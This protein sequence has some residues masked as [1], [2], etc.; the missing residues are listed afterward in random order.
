MDHVD[1][2]VFPITYVEVICF[3]S[4]NLYFSTVLFVRIT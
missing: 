2:N 4:T 3:F 1:K